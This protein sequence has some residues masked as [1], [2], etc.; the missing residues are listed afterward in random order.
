MLSD[1]SVTNFR[2]IRE[3]E[4]E[5]HPSG[6]GIVGPNGSGKT[7]LLEAIYFLGHGRSF[8]T[9]ARDVLQGPALDL[10]RVVARLDTP[11]TRL[12]A[13]IEF[14][15]GETRLRVGGRASTFAEFASLLPMQ[16]VDP[17]VHRLV[18]EGSMRRRR[19]LDWGVFH[20]EHSFVDP[21]RRFQRALLQRNAALRTG[22]PESAVRVWDA[23]LIQ[24]G[25][26]IDQHRERYLAALQP[27]FATV[28]QRLLT[29]PITL[30]YRKGWSGEVSFAQALADSFP[31]D[32][33]NRT[34]TVGPHRA[35]LTFRIEGMT[36]RERV[37]R[38]QQKMLAASLV[39][40]QTALRAESPG[41]A[42]C[43]LLDDPA[44]EL[45]VDNLGKLLA[46]V[47][48]LRAQLIVTAVSERGLEGLPIER[49]FH[50]EQGAFERVL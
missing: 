42:T 49:M 45:D 4:L 31:R 18:E 8:R 40:A 5:F 37:S 27:V 17:G 30:G 24:A 1:I 47:A 19:Q 21:W 14:A 39:L 26:L 22:S 34:T 38:G 12:T 23:E 50:V 43:L 35:D 41:P 46:V 10:F 20:V 15:D 33:R 2:C 25:D 29:F 16:I 9:R 3:A 6:T 7:S 48:S 44:A 11:P 28:T 13:G 32:S 36:A